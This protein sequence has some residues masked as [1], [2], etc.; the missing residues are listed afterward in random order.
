MD[1]FEKPTLV[2]RNGVHLL[3]TMVWFDPT[4]ASEFCA[5]SSAAQPR[6]RRH[7]RALWSDRTA[8]LV[9]SQG[10][11]SLSGLAC[12]YRHSF[13]LGPLVFELIPSGYMPGACQYL[14]RFPNGYTLLYSGPFSM[15]DSLTSEPIEF[16]QC[17]TL[18]LDATYGD[19]QFQFPARSTIYTSIKEWISQELVGT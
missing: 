19:P 11:F 9:E 10:G 2:Y 8:R 18:L 6:L 4:R 7:Q 3:G 12:P 14:L 1:A 15:Q 5:I 13:N 16:G 17:D